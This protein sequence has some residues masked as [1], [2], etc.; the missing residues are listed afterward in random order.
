[1]TSLFTSAAQPSKIA[2]S[3]DHSSGSG[4]YPSHVERRRGVN[5]TQTV[6]TAN[7]SLENLETHVDVLCAFLDEEDPGASVNSS[8][9]VDLR[10]LEW[11]KYIPIAEN[12]TD[13]QNW[14]IFDWLD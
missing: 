10:N 12:L 9:F 2:T 11:I 5:Q 13:G 14:A 3:E 6:Q 4:G 7:D 1:M 8:F